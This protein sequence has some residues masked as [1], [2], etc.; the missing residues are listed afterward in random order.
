MKKLGPILIALL[1]SSCSS[2][3]F[4]RE[5]NA[6]F[7]I[8]DQ[9]HDL[10]P[11]WVN[12]FHQE[13]RDKKDPLYEFFHGESGEVSDRLAG[14]SLSL[15]QAKRNLGQQIASFVSDQVSSKSKGNINIG[16][17]F[18]AENDE[19]TR[20]FKEEIVTKSMAFVHGVKVYDQFWQERGH[21]I[22]GGPRKIFLCQTVIKVGHENIQ[23]AIHKAMQLAKGKIQQEENSDS[24]Q[25]TNE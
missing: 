19:L 6:N 2:Q 3:S 16:G 7:V 18:M 22:T 4:K 13:F 5:K 23:R 21:S 9:S 17:P 14:C 24:N 15:L 11:K 1:I 12:N 20:Q 10:T 8:R 25:T